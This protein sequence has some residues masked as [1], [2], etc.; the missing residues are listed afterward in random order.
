VRVHGTRHLNVELPAKL[1]FG[2][3]V[4][5]GQLLVQRHLVVEGI[6]Y[7]NLYNLLFWCRVE[8]SV[9]QVNQN[10]C[11]FLVAKEPF[12]GVIHFWVNSKHHIGSLSP[13]AHTPIDKPV[14]RFA[15]QVYYTIEIPLGARPNCD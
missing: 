11:V 8:N 13:R 1:V 6:E 9:E 4:E 14:P 15:G 7:L 10:R 2:F 12:E 3:D 5:N